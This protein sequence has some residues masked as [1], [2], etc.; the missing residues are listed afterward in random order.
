MRSQTPSPLISPTPTPQ[1]PLTLVI[2]A[3][4]TSGCLLASRLA[5]TPSKPS[6]ALLEGGGDINKPE[7]RRTAERFSTV[8]QPGLDYGYLSTPQAQAQGRE[9]PQARGK[10]LGGSSAVNF[11]V[12][13]LGAREEFDAWA[14]A[15]GDEAWG[16]DSVV[17]RVRQ[18]RERLEDCKG[19]VTCY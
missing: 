7:Y 16:F 6:V 8:A 15:A 9:V 18:V 5:N 1:Q 2:N 3:G 14:E 10:G 11:Q 4:G 13:S 19:C 17:E 12:W